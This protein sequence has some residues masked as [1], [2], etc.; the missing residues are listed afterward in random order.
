MRLGWML[1]GLVA[2]QGVTTTEITTLTS[3]CADGDDLIVQFAGCLSS[4]CD[5]L[6][7]A[8]C[9]AELSGGNLRVTGKATV[10]HQGRECTDDC[11]LI[12]ASCRIPEGAEGSAIVQ[13]GGDDGGELLQDAACD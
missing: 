12:S 4:S 6:V 10:D 5:T 8:S 9:E 13:L 3:A 1:M 11:G 2:C 7:S